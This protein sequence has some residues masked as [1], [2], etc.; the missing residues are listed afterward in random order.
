MKKLLIGIL[1]AAFAAGNAYPQSERVP[2]SQINPKD[3]SKWSIAIGGGYT[4]YRVN[5]FT[6]NS[7]E[8]FWKFYVTGEGGMISN[9]GNPQISV[10]YDFN[11]LFGIGLHIGRFGFNRPAGD[12]NTF[13]E[14]N[15]D[16]T[17]RRNAE[18]QYIVSK[19]TDINYGAVYDLTLYGS[20]DVTDLLLPYRKWK[21]WSVYAD[22]GMGV[23]YYHGKLA[24]PYHSSIS[25]NVDI[26]TGYPHFEEGVYNGLTPMFSSLLNA[27]YSF[28]RR[29]A[30]G[31][32]FGYRAYIRDGL[33]G[34]DEESV[35]I[36]SPNRNPQ[37]KGSTEA[38]N[39]D[40]WN[41]TLSLRFKLGTK[42]IHMRDVRLTETFIV[43]E[44]DPVEDISPLLLKRMREIEGANRDLQNRI[45]ELEGKI[46][47]LHDPILGVSGT[48][49]PPD[50][51]VI[52]GV[53][54]K[55]DKTILI[56]SS[57]PILQDVLAKLIV[58]KNEWSVLKIDGHTDAFGSVEYNDDLGLRR[59][60]AI[61]QYFI[62][63]GLR[64]KTFVVESFGKSK[65]VAPNSIGGKD[66]P[67][68]RQE[69]RRVELYILE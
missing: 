9:Y 13:Y 59:A 44:R 68:G 12:P 26:W 39:E 32:A 66:N 54:F 8:G 63:N 22:F 65:P 47:K 21:N 25:N 69:N 49:T 2:L 7:Q 62:E 38:Q 48:G 50:P 4:Y 33:G 27:E 52:Q 6:Q 57:I 10:E 41:A 37:Y 40:G 67:A 34:Y 64:G 15:K 51:W 55:F 16:G 20:I 60:N 42:K 45:D 19:V 24:D 31:L 17:L 36:G 18:S 14:K 5:P 3:Y 28:G 58:H 23:G 56:E 53:N 1:L 46:D 30:L 29:I 11:P 43:E 61:K 35:T